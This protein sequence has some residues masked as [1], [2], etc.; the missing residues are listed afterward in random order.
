V[1][2]LVGSNEEEGRSL[3]DLSVVKA[4][5]FDAD[6]ARAFGPLPPTLMAA[7][8]HATDPQAKQARADFE[9]DL[10]FGWDMWAWARLQAA[11]GKRP[12]FYYH[13]IQRPP[14]PAPSIYAGWGASHFAELWYV[15]GHLGQEPWPWTSHDRALSDA[16][17][18]YWTNFAK[19]GDPNG[20][21]LSVWPSFTGKDGKTLYLGTPMT[22]GGVADLSSLEVFDAVYAQVRA[23]GPGPNKGPDEEGTR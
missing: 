18:S 4:A 13:F 21:A 23:A 5:S 9:R 14:F 6:I 8:P 17:M 22:V 19:T 16:M 3:V 11:T 15:F 1:P 2:L 12:V 10:R 20:P 7:Y